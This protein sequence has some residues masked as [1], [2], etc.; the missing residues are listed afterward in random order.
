MGRMGF[1][2]ALQLASF[3]QF[4]PYFLQT[5]AKTHLSN[6][7]SMFFPFY[8]ITVIGVDVHHFRNITVYSVSVM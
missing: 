8:V 6:R 4:S 5:L 2:N 7:I 1:L 3:E